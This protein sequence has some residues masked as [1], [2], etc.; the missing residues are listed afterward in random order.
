MSPEQAVIDAAEKLVSRF[1]ALCPDPTPELA[2]LVL[3]LEEALYQRFAV[4]PQW[5]TVDGW[6]EDNS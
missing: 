1:F 5:A 2:L 3:D 6:S 4:S